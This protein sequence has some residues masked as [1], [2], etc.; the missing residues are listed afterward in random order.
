MAT[1]KLGSRPKS[2]ARVV[3]YK[4]VDGADLSLPVTFKYRT[5]KEYGEWHDSLPE[6]PQLEGKEVDGKTVYSVEDL[7]ERRSAWNAK[8]ISQSVD[9][10]GL[11][12][13]FND[14]NVK[15]LCDESPAGADAVI[16]EYRAAIIEGRLGN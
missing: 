6:Y 5:R 10:W 15:Q 1:V 3:K 9:S 2:F 13:E 11:D 12:V 7:L 16:E 4:D 8:R 14:A